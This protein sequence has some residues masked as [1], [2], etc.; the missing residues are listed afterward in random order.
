M[1]YKPWI[2]LFF[3]FLLMTAGMR[4]GKELWAQSALGVQPGGV[5]SSCPAPVAKAMIFCNVTGDPA[6]PDGSYLSM[7]GGAY[8][9]IQTG[10]AAAGV[11]SFNKRT[12][13]VLPTTSDY[14]YSQLSG[15]PTTLNCTTASLTTTGGLVASNCTIK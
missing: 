11:T 9:Q 14:S 12:G 1:K 5:L 7:N 6:N 15:P 8:A 2:V 4:A 13:A 3:A 10:A